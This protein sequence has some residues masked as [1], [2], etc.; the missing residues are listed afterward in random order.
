MINIEYMCHPQSGL[1]VFN[2][3]CTGK[4]QGKSDNIFFGIVNNLCF[5]TC[6][7]RHH[8]WVIW[9]AHNRTIFGYAQ[10]KLVK[11]TLNIGQ[12]FVVIEVVE[13]NVR[14][15]QNSRIE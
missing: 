12:I 2:I 14:Y 1:R 11:G 9:I 5:Y 4:S 15:D 7:Y 6:K 13:V 8:M 10:S 3:M